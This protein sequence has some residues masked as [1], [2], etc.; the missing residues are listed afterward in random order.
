MNG[1]VEQSA[2]KD[3]AHLGTRC[4]D[5]RWGQAPSCVHIGRMLQGQSV[6]TKRIS[7]HFCAVTGTV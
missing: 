6:H 4:G 2:T 3:G 1:L 5:V 7:V